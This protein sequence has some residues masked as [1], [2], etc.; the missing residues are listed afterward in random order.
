VKNTFICAVGV[1][2]MSPPSQPRARAKTA[3]AAISLDFME[4][5]P[6]EHNNASF[7]LA[8]FQEESCKLAE[9]TIQH[10]G[11]WEREEVLASLRGC[12]RAAAKSQH[13][14]KVLEAVVLHMSIDEAAFIADELLGYGREALLDTTTCSVVCRLVEHSPA[15]DRTIALVDEI[16]S[17]DVAS[18]C[19]HKYGHMVAMTILAC[20]VAR[21]VEQV[22]CALR[23]NPQRFARHRFA[24]KVVEVALRSAAVGFDSLCR[25][26][27]AQPGTVVNLACHNFGVHVARAL[28]ESPRHTKQAMHFLMKSVRRLAKD[29]YGRELMQEYGLVVMMPTLN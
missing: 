29:K 9:D 2:E 24:S 15:D 17:C 11:A 4:A 13:G 23:S 19:C 3:G 18:L 8:G 1:E 12:V 28:L 7:G 25:E 22:V 6:T 5:S 20:G 14:H 26:M 16:L 10:A 21:Q 27:I